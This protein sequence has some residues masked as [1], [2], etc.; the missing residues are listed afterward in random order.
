M[1]RLPGVLFLMLGCIFA[2]AALLLWGFGAW[3]R[4]QAA[5]TSGIVSE[6]SLRHYADGNSYCPVVHFRVRGQVY[7]HYS[8]ICS[9]PASYEQGQEVRLWYDPNDPQRVQLDD[10]VGNWLLPL[11]FG[12]V[13]LLFIGI[14]TFSLF[15][16][17]M[18]R[19]RR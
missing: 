18:E 15:P 14:G 8:D 1:T 5:E 9:W 3:F 7:T 10:F 12:G 19:W 13:G 16:M 11:I 6:V 2:L 4:A 17:I